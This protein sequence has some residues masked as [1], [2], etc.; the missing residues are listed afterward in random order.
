LVVRFNNCVLLFDKKIDA[1]SAENIG[2]ILRWNSIEKLNMEKHLILILRLG[3]LQRARSDREQY[4][5]E[6]GIPLANFP[7]HPDSLRNFEHISINW[8][9]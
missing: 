4:S 5:S 9:A 1:S 2:T 8:I 3:S 7:V 6:H